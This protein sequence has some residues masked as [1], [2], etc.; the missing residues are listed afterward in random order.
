MKFDL[1]KDWDGV[2]FAKDGDE[3]TAELDKFVHGLLDKNRV[4]ERYRAS[5]F[6]DFRIAVLNAA[7]TARSVELTERANN[8]AIIDARRKLEAVE[9]AARLLPIDVNKHVPSAHVAD[10]FAA[11]R[12]LAQAREALAEV[13][14]IFEPLARVR[15]E[16]RRNTDISQL[17]FAR[18]LEFEWKR[19]TVAPMHKAD[20]CRFLEV[21][22]PMFGIDSPDAVRHSVFKRKKILKAE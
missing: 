5:A 13:S 8:R 18:N 6:R 19:L 4:A 22:F 7:T 3:R 16:N 10:M 12:S 11:E 2:I 14:N 17:Q 21:A 15:I 1:L 20:F 9:R